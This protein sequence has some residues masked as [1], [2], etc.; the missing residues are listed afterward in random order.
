MRNL[1][2]LMLMPFLWQCT[3]GP[4][5]TELMQMNDSLLVETAKKEIQLNQLVETLGDI[6][7]NLRLIKEKEQII[8]VQAE[9]G[10]MRGR[11]GE[12][13]NEDIQLIYE[14]MVQNKD[15]IQQLEAQLRN[16][17]VE[18]N[19]VNRLIA[20][21]NEQL[22]EKSAQIVLLQ[23]Q[24]QQRELV[25]D[26]LNLEIMDLSFEM[27]SIRKAGEATRQRL[28]QTT[29]HY[30]RAWYTMG[31]RRE[32]RDQNILTRE[33]F[34]FFGSTRILKEDF[35]KSYF[36]QIDIR[37]KDTIQ[38]YTSKAEVLSNHPSGSF[39]MV[40]GEEGNLILVI[41][42]PELFWSITRYLVIQVN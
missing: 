40:T 26:H 42:D 18:N 32:L 33:G 39:Q 31:T 16:S 2:L 21:L 29:D 10:D 12:Q 38:L 24:L 23:E 7:E 30:N 6:D 34:L 5:R 35:D 13:I 15:R 41:E 11:T 19:R 36:Q 20:G 28:D 8:S 9:S 37:E 22:Q 27:D 3:S 4:S 14:L 1:I 25:I 17:G